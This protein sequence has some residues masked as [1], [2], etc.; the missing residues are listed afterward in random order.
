[1]CQLGGSSPENL[2][3]ASRIVE[4]Y[5]YDE[6]NLNVHRRPPAPPLLLSS[7]HFAGARCL[8][9][10]SALI[11]CEAG[12]EAH[13]SRARASALLVSSR[14]CVC[15]S[16][17][18]PG[19]LPEPKSRLQEGRGGVLRRAA[20]VRPRPCGGVP[21]ARPPRGGSRGAR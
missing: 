11:C 21:Q 2:A 14:L 12:R 3:A 16:L 18:Y 9:R 13:N 4:E 1:M 15:V 7:P 10:V 20:H 6:V 19:R 8:H 5:G 17:C